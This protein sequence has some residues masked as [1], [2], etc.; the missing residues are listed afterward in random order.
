[1]TIRLL[2]AAPEADSIAL[3]DSLLEAA[4]QL[5][6]LDIR[7]HHVTTRA[8]L[9]QRI[10]SRDDDVLLLDWLLTGADTPQCL[11]DLFGL[12]PGLRTIVVMPLHLRQYR[13]CL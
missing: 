12:H 5:L 11:H 4:L 7:V 13:A 3:Y 2:I 9:A 6:P 10:A 1:M 8:A